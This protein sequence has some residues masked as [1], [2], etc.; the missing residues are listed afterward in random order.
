MR[1]GDGIW[2]WR[3]ARQKEN[4]EKKKKLWQ[5]ET[6]PPSFFPRHLT[7]S[8]LTGLLDNPEKITFFRNYYLTGF[9]HVYY[10]E[11]S[12]GR[13]QLCTQPAERAIGVVCQLLLINAAIFSRI[14]VITWRLDAMIQRYCIDF[15][16]RRRLFLQ[17]S[18]RHI[19]FL[20]N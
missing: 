10:F 2:K 5:M 6:S 20:Q 8:R 13:K 4:L 17:K 9:T 15:R 16:V 1:D 19:C 12:N 7:I 11:I 3:L 18:N 14:L